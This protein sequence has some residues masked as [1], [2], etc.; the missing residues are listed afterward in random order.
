MGGWA[1]RVAYLGRRVRDRAGSDAPIHPMDL[2]IVRSLWV[3]CTSGTVAARAVV[4]R[5]DR[6][7]R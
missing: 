2:C 3:A 6:G 4:R 7:V 5:I 1:R